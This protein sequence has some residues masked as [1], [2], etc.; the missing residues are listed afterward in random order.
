MSA[1]AGF[2][3]GLE[4]RGGSMDGVRGDMAVGQSGKGLMGR[5]AG[6]GVGFSPHLP[7]VRA[8]YELVCRH[9]AGVAEGMGTDLMD[10]FRADELVS[11]LFVSDEDQ[12]NRPFCRRK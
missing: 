4:G 12:F 2:G 9:L 6:G 7:C 5:S 11:A 1:R 8:K 3:G 10:A